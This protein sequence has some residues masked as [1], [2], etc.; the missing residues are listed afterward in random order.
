MKLKQEN[1]DN[2]NRLNSRNLTINTNTI[3]NNIKDN[4]A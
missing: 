1:Y 3:N 4:Y 2:L